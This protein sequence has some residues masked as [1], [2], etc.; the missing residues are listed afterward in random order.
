M[1]A[2]KDDAGHAVGF[3]PNEAADGFVEGESLADFVGAFQSAHD[4]VEVELLGAMGEASSNDLGGRIVD[5]SSHGAV[6]EVFEGDD[7]AGLGL[8]EGFFDFGCVN[9]VVALKDA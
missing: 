7:V 5:G 9:P 3:G 6:F 4:E 1:K 2:I 8:A